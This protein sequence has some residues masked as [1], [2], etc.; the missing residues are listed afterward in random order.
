MLFQL[1][2]GLMRAS[3]ATR[4]FFDNNNVF[5]V[6]KEGDRVRFIGENDELLT[7]NVIKH[8]MKHDFDNNAKVAFMRIETINSTILMVPWRSSEP[9]N[10]EIKEI[11][12]G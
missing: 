6:V 3:D 9:T 5:A 8:E 2:S 12:N 11:Q 4:K 10:N 1:E 7:S